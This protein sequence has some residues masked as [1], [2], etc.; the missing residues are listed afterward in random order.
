MALKPAFHFVGRAILLFSAVV[1]LAEAWPLSVW[2]AISFAGWMVVRKSEKLWVKALAATLG[3]VTCG[4]LAV[5]VILTVFGHLPPS[6]SRIPIAW[7][8][9]EVLWLHVVLPAW[10]KPKAWQVIGVLTLLTLLSYFLPQWKL[11]QRFGSLKKVVAQISAAAAVAASFT[12][13]SNECV[14]QPMA[15]DTH[16]RLQALWREAN[17]A[18]GKYLATEVAAESLKKALETLPPAK[19]ATYRAMLE[20]AAKMRDR[21]QAGKLLEDFFEYHR[22]GSEPGG[23]SSKDEAKG[24]TE[25]GK[26]KRKAELSTPPED[27]IVEAV[28]AQMENARTEKK[29]ATD[30]EEGVKAILS[31]GFEAENEP[32]K[33]LVETFTKELLEPVL[34]PLTETVTGYL[35]EMTGGALDDAREEMFE[36][37]SQ[38]LREGVSGNASALSELEK[39]EIPKIKELTAQLESKLAAVKAKEDALRVKYP[40]QQTMSDRAK[41]YN[42]RMFL[43]SEQA[44]LGPVAAELTKVHARLNALEGSAGGAAQPATTGPSQPMVDL[45]TKA[46]RQMKEAEPIT[47]AVEIRNAEFKAH[48]ANVHG[49]DSKGGPHP[50]EAVHEPGPRAMH[51]P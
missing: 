12:F 29:K 24:G 23:T 44:G 39:P 51:I 27:R 16:Q 7:I 38:F 13:F 9:K 17:A 26:P 15:D 37:F 41:S 11:V 18:E 34:G 21:D 42:E 46:D 48:E 4:L 47:K 50:G 22:T 10:A 19:L 3:P 8:E 33:E 30:A 49:L 36:K 40:G 31:A 2:L 20:A 32:L 43:E 5:A 14:I 25:G 28:T 6:E 45:L 1:F 35:G